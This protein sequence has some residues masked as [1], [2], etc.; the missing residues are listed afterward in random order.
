MAL[1]VFLVG[2]CVSIGQTLMLGP[3]LPERVASHFG[4]TGAADGFMARGTFILLQWG[5]AGFLGALFI[6]LPVLIRATPEDAINLPNKRYWLAPE[7]R[8]LTLA[9]LADRFFAFG[10]AT[11]ALLASVLQLVYEA[12]LR[13]SSNIDSLPWLYLAVYLAYTVIWSIT[14]LRRFSVSTSDFMP[15]R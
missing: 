6:G 9:Y 7:R 11:L 15:P 3:L 4:P 13:D 5:I 1:W 12:N 8:E 10:A 2:I 14:L